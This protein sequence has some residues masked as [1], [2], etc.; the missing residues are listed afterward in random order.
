MQVGPYLDVETVGNSYAPEV[1]QWYDS[2]TGH[3]YK[4]DSVNGTSRADSMG[5]HTIN[6]KV[7]DGHIATINV[8]LTVDDWGCF[9]LFSMDDPETMIL[10]LGMMKNVDASP[11]PRG[12]HTIW[13]KSGS[14]QLLPGDYRMVIYHENATYV[15]EYANEVGTNVAQCDFVISATK[16]RFVNWPTAPVVLGNPITWYVAIQ[17]SSAKLYK[18]NTGTISEL[19]AEEFG[20]MARVIFAEASNDYEDMKA[21]AAVMLNRLGN[22]RGNAFRT[23]V[24]SILDEINDSRITDKKPNPPKYWVGV[25]NDQYKSVQGENYKNI[26][27]IS[28]NKLI[29]VIDALHEIVRSG[30]A[31]Y[32]FTFYDKNA[33][34]NDVKIGVHYF[35]TNRQYATCTDL[36][37]LKNSNGVYYDWDELPI[38]QGSPLDTS[39]D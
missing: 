18:Y 28:K 32:P 22:S 7:P 3:Y 19:S 26:D 20:E 33:E 35:K 38:Y 10:H 23:P 11:G 13:S 16:E 4:S 29:Q 24:L 31:G 17:D 39:N 27:T 6:F 1:S 36:S 25:N 2:I 34:P 12:G 5:D 14:V 8:T 9:D 30:T 21:I 37:Q 15:P